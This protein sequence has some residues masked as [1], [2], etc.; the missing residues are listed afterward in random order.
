MKL[1][2][3]IQVGLLLSASVLAAEEFREQDRHFTL[4]VQPV[5]SEKCNGCHGDDP[6]KIKGGF[7]MLT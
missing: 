4:K 7:N 3:L 1:N 2:A 5:L 6:E